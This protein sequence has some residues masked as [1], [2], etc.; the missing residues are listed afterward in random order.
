[1]PK[2]RKERPSSTAGKTKGSNCQKS[3][4]KNLHAKDTK[5]YRTN[6]KLWKKACDAVDK[7]KGNRPGVHNFQEEA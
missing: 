6:P 7:E 2:S 3:E 1:M 4:L 5:L